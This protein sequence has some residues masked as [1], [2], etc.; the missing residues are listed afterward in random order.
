VFPDVPP[1]ISE[2]LKAL[3]C[4]A[5]SDRPRKAPHVAAEMEMPPSQTAK[6]LQQLT[7]AGFVESRRGAGGGFLLIRPAARI[8]VADVFTLFAHRPQKQEL[9]D[10]VAQ[11]LA[12][13]GEK[14][15][16]ELNRITIADIAQRRRASA[17]KRHARQ[18]ERKKLGKGISEEG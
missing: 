14:Y 4:L 3:C 18:K 15:R 7:W 12:R 2:A 1:R 9:Q 8:R 10:P 11:I 17:G 5:R 16:R 13:A 6:I